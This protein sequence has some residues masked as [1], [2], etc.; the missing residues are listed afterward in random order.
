MALA[1]ARR[2]GHS[3]Q[4]SGADSQR[5]RGFHSSSSAVAIL[6]IGSALFASACQQ[7]DCEKYA[8]WGLI[9]NVAD[10]RGHTI[11]DATVTATAGDYSEELEIDRVEPGGSCPYHG[12]L[13]RK[14]TYSII[15]RKSGASTT[16][17][18]V[19]V[20]ADSCHVRPV[21]TTISLSE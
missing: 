15:V 1:P 10:A 21:T 9:V 19:E 18:G 12:A 4:V 6:L 20:T 3:A 14:G 8:A 2:T 11:C 5:F 16:L 7:A 13:E 17:D